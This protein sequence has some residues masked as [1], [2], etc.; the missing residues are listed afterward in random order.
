MANTNCA[1]EGVSKLTWYLFTVVL[2]A[3]LTLSG[4]WALNIE[5]T[6]SDLRH[7]DSALRTEL[8]ASQINVAVQEERLKSIDEKVD[9]ILIKLDKLME[10]QK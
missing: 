3:V 4:A 1:K 10:A 6:T 8:K 7:D 9:K 5:Q 2:A